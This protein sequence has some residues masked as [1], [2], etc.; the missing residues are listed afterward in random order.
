MIH[1]KAVSTGREESKSVPH[2]TQKLSRDAAGKLR[3]DWLCSCP[4]LFNRD[5]PI[6]L[7]SDGNGSICALPLG[8][9]NSTRHVKL[10]LCSIKK[11]K[12]IP[13]PRND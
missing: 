11:A 1:M 7:K 8:S 5:S 4:I 6:Q 10:A 3:I 2:F 12:L 13:P 9:W